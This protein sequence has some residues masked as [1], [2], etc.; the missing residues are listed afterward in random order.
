MYTE[1]S[2]AWTKARAQVYAHAPSTDWED[3]LALDK[4]NATGAH[5]PPRFTA[6]ALFESLRAVTV[7]GIGMELQRFRNS[8]NMA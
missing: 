1:W 2:R 6:G 5:G 3:V 4:A 8:F 7:F